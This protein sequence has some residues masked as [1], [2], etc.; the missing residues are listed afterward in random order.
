MPAGVHL[1]PIGRAMIWVMETNENTSPESDRRA[2][3]WRRYADAADA[4]ARRDADARTFRADALAMGRV[5]D[6]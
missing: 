3:S 5:G 1:F 6:F 4:R 2:A